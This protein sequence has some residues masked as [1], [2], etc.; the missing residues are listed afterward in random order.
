VKSQEDGHWIIRVDEADFIKTRYLL[1]QLTNP[2]K[3]TKIL[4]LKT[5]LKE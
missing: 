2:H 4:Q 1:Q 5:I 3:K